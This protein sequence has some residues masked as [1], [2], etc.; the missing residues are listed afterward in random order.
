MAIQFPTNPAIGQQLIVS[1]SGIVYTWTGTIWSTLPV[2]GSSAVRVNEETGFPVFTDGKQEFNWIGSV[3]GNPTSSGA[4]F[5]SNA[6]WI[7][8]NNYDGVILTN[9]INNQNGSV[10]WS[11]SSV[12]APTEENPL[13]ITFW[14]KAN[15][16]GEGMLFH[17]N[18]NSPLTGSSS[19]TTVQAKDGYTV[20]FDDDFILG[21]SI[22]TSYLSGSSPATSPLT[23]IPNDLF[24]RWDILLYKSGSNY[25]QNMWQSQAKETGAPDK[26][27]E[28]VLLSLFD[29]NDF[30]LQ[31]NKNLGP[32]WPTGS[33]FGFQGFTTSANASHFVNN[34]QIRSGNL[35]PPTYFGGYIK[36]GFQ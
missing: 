31:V 36:N 1:S 15:G 19:S 6:F 27:N 20:F 14:S 3:H 24:N 4:T 8:S 32:V 35:L 26:M 13:W 21:I 11:G 33:Y 34:L 5:F 30:P 18:A 29:G 22:I 23:A 16:S 7:T 9:P 12:V 2:S 17:L 10:Y 25:F 28:P